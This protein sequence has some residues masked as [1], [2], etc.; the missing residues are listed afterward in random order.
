MNNFEV[1]MLLKGRFYKKYGKVDVLLG[2]LIE[3][4]YGLGL[5]DLGMP[6][7]LK[8]QSINLGVPSKLKNANSP[9][10]L[11]GSRSDNLTFY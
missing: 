6:V 11:G 8:N 1:E 5:M 10:F 2:K 3:A 9:V 4:K 7:G